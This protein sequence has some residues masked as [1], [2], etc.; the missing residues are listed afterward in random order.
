MKEVEE[1]ERLIEGAAL[2]CRH[3]RSDIRLRIFKC[4]IRIEEEGSSE[5]EEEEEDEFC[6]SRIDAL[7]DKRGR[8]D[9]K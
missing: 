3:Q 2:D 5:N 6:D 1:F 8:D 4:D 9:Q 7:K